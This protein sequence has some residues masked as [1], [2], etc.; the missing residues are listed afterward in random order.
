MFHKLP[1]N[2][3]E[4]LENVVLCRISVLIFAVFLVSIGRLSQ[5]QSFFFPP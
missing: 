5:V 3:N 1:G 4:V 2:L